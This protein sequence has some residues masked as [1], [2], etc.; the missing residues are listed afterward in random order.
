MFSF[1]LQ[2][3][4]GAPGYKGRPGPKGIRVNN[5]LYF[6]LC[7]YLLWPFVSLF[8]SMFFVA[9]RS[10]CSWASWWQRISWFNCMS[11][12]KLIDKLYLLLNNSTDQT[13]SCFALQG[14]PGRKVCTE[15]AGVIVIYIALLIITLYLNQVGTA[16]R[17]ILRSGWP[18][19][20]WHA[21]MTQTT[22]Y[23]GVT[24]KCWKYIYYILSLWKLQRKVMV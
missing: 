13:D 4:Q 2:G 3:K 19:V 22:M 17:Q 23:S 14:P 6:I 10:W 24:S 12:C 16:Q 7:T 15:I 9:G 11:L 20:P 1:I 5:F 18:V 8:I 21:V